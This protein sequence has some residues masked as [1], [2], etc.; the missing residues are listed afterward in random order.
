MR[1]RD[2]SE[3]SVQL[4]YDEAC[5][6]IRCLDFLSASANLCD[7]LKNETIKMIHLGNETN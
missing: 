6:A 2:K 5:K 4:E 1:D 7:A 3:D